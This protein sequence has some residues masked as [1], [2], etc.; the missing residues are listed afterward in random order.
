LKS[1]TVLARDRLYAAPGA[2]VNCVHV[3][4][5]SICKPVRRKKANIN[6]KL[7]ETRFGVVGW[8]HLVENKAWQ[9]RFMNFQNVYE[10]GIP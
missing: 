3:R 4:C 5:I 9:S 2:S 7:K 1:F 8:I 10:L 6:I